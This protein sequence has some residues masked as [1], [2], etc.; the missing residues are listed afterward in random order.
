MYSKTVTG[1]IYI[2]TLHT[3]IILKSPSNESEQSILWGGLKVT[4]YTTGNFPFMGSLWSYILRL[5]MW[6]IL[7]HICG[8]VSR[9]V[10]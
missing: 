3:Y 5:V 4:K 6:Y 2:Q 8:T 10:I 7:Q 9:G 1:Y